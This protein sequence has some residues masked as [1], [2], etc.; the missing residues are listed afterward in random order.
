MIAGHETSSATLTWTLFELCRNP[1]VQ[2]KL[3]EEI[4]AKEAKLIE[5]GKTG[6]TAQDFETMPYLNAVVKVRNPIISCTI[7]E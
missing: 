2:T 6:F 7:V 5:Q 4:R 1:Q 3:R